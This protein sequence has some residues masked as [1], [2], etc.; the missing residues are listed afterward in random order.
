MSAKAWESELLRRQHS[1][2]SWLLY[3]TFTRRE[4]PGFERRK[5]FL[6]YYLKKHRSLQKYM[7]ESASH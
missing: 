3:I 5:I 4:E 7:G 6:P 1:P 2:V